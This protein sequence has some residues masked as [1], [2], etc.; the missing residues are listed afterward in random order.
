MFDSGNPEMNAI[1][2]SSGRAGAQLKGSEI[3]D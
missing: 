3:K 1:K 2:R